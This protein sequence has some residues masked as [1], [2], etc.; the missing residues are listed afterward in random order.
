[1]IRPIARAFSSLNTSGGSRFNIKNAFQR[2]KNTVRAPVKH[3][4]RNVEASPVNYN[5]FTNTTEE[6]FDEVSQ[7]W[8]A[9][10]ISNPYDT[11]TFNMLEQAMVQNFGTVDN[12]HVIFTSDAPFR[13][14]GCTGQANEDDYEGH[15]FLM[16][17]LREGPLQRCPSCGQ[18]YKLVRLRNEF[19]PEMD[20]YLSNLIPYAM[21][22]MGEMDT[23]IN[24][25]VFRQQK[26][27]Y[28]YSQFETPSNMVYN[29]VNPDEHDRLLTDPAYRLERTKKLEEKFYVYIYSLKEIEKEYTANFGPVPRFPVNK[30][31]YETLIDVEKAIM[32]LDRL[33]RKVDKFNNRKYVDRENHERREKRMQERAKE[34]WESNY[35]FFY[36][37]LTE[38]EQ[39]YRDYFQT[40]LER[41]PEDEEIESKLDENEIMA[42]G[43]YDLNKFD[44]Q[45]LYTRQ[46]EDDATSYLEK[47]AFKFKYRQARD[48]AENYAR[49][50]SR[51][52]QRQLDRLEKKN[53]H[54][55]VAELNE[56]ISNN[57]NV[58][59]VKLEKQYLDILAD[60]SVNQYRD[61]FESDNEEDFTVLD[62]IP[63]ADKVTF[64]N[65][66]ENYTVPLGDNKGFKTI[67]KTEFSETTGLWHNF[68]NTI[69]GYNSLVFP[70]AKELANVSQRS[71]SDP[72]SNEELRKLGIYESTERVEE[73]PRAEPIAEKP[74]QKAEA[75]KVTQATQTQS[76]TQNQQTQTKSQGQG[77][78]GKW[79]KPNKH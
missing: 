16:F 20:Y 39:K 68:F 38:E 65:V 8:Q 69:R 21:E 34:R 11:N 42:S 23:L 5:P 74:A 37:G 61:Y 50:Q 77:K 75:P 4:K 35:A 10:L 54:E 48:T 70:R 13:Y 73:K 64:M 46:P 72:F 58:S 67:P 56:A 49:R 33:F 22:E 1:M 18:V 63:D 32:K 24:M 43:D 15:E 26:D 60:E 66:F 47:K 76:Q 40:D 6:A 3:F 79:N 52:I 62:N 51:T 71:E 36:G 30:V 19:S 2:L 53:F 59:R 28:E 17:M 9:L 78:G 44:F 45:E 14:V 27:T 12:P 41:D 25:S 31:D 7:E 57:D 29:L 55:I